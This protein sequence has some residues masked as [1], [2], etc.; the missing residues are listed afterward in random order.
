MLLK[1]ER[2]LWLDAAK[3]VGILLVLIGHLGI[4]MM[5]GARQVQ[6][7]IYSFHMPLFFFLSG[8]LFSTGKNLKDFALKKLRSIVLPY[9]VF[10]S[11]MVLYCVYDSVKNNYYSEQWLS[12]LVRHVVVQDHWWTIWFLAC[13]LVLNVMMYPMV[14]LLKRGWALALTAG[15]LAAAG[16]LYYR[17]GGGFLPWNIDVAFCAM[18]F[19]CCGYLVRGHKAAFAEL[20]SG[21]KRKLCV[22]LACAAGNILFCW[23][24][25]KHCGQVPDMLAMRY[26]AA[27]LMYLSAFFGIVAVLIVSKCLNLKPIFFIGA[28]SLV[29]FTLH[30]TVIMPIVKNQMAYVRFTIAAG[31]PAGKM[32]LYWGIEMAAMLLILTAITMLINGTKL[33]YL[34]GKK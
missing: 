10:G 18:P 13:I 30:Q 6:V 7:W 1:R 34:I 5:P 28:N 17:F 31:D 19:F 23:L 9:F 4:E 20:V 14:R 33:H 22:F 26:G 24:N 25:Y 8:Y 29:Y 2:I 15:L 16:L 3:G 32:L 27:P 12:D 21:V 11:V